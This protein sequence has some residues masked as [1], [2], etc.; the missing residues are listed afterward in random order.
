MDSDLVEKVHHELWNDLASKDSF[1]TTSPLLAH[2]TSVSTLEKI[3]SSE[4]VWFSNPL[5]MND[6]EELRFGMNEG[7]RV[8][9]ENDSLKAACDRIGKYELLIDSFNS[10][11][12]EYA[13]EYAFDTYV[14]C[15]SEHPPENT[16]GVLSMWRG[17]GANGGGVPLFPRD[18]AAAVVRTLVAV[19][20]QCFAGIGLNP[21]P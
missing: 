8:F 1:P 9:R 5:F 3:V 2:Y 12:H 14:F 6:L 17:Y 18:L 15:L 10:M 4:E 20:R 13:T 7:A 11:F 16:D 19:E 21:H